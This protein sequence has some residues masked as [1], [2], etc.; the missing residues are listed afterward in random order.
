[1]LRVKCNFRQDVQTDFQQFELFIQTLEGVWT[2]LPAKMYRK[3]EE[4]GKAKPRFPTRL[5]NV[6]Y[7]ISQDPTNYCNFFMVR[8]NSL[9]NDQG[10]H[11][12]VNRND[13]TS[14]EKSVTRF[15][16]ELALG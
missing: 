1:M 10:F 3:E 5:E 9:L 8:K 16:S 14:L 7:L 12:I 4:K 2:S 11:L 15:I 13:L 6:I